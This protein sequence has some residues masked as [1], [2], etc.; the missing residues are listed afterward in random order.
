MSISD[1]IFSAVNHNTPDCGEPPRWLREKAAGSRSY[2]ENMHGEQWI[3]EASKDRLRRT[4]GEIGSDRYTNEHPDHNDDQCAARYRF[5]RARSR[6]DGE[7][8]PLALSARSP[9]AIA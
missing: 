3:A 9:C 1:P 8:S 6:G 2:F 7:L 5:S 4:G